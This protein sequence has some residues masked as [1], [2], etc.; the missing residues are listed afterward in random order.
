LWNLASDI[1][2]PKMTFQ[3]FSFPRIDVSVKI[4]SS[5]KT[6]SEILVELS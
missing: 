3:E 5:G 2:M 4:Q 1:A 6:E